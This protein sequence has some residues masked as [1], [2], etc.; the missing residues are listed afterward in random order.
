VPLPLLLLLLPQFNPAMNPWKSS[1]VRAYMQAYYAAALK[2]LQGGAPGG[3]WRVRGVFAWN[4]VS[5]DVQ[6]VHPLSYA[7]DGGSFKGEQVR[8]AARLLQGQLQ[9][10]GWKCGGVV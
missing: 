3:K 6:G 4:L 9:L 8:C 2:W 10:R 5:W 7:G 1:A